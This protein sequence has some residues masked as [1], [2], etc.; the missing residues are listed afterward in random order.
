M[1]QAGAL[2]TTA[3]GGGGGGGDLDQIN[4]DTGSAIPVGGIITINS[5]GF[6]TTSASGAVLTVA[7]NDAT[8]GSGSTVEAVTTDLVTQSAGGTPTVYR[9]EAYIALFDSATP[10]GGG[11]TIYATVRTN[12]SSTTLVGTPSKFVEEE[13]AVSTADANI[14]VS[15]NDF[16]VRVTG[17]VGL[18]LSWNT[19]VSWVAV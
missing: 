3:G 1:S 19:K 10:S 5:D 18:T 4:A 15:G 16:I 2:T 7:L 13:S 9:I 12:G 8:S 14:V 11:Y 17:V 6:L